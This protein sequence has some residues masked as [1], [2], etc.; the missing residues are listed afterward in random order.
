MRIPVSTSSPTMIPTAGGPP[1]ENEPPEVPSESRLRQLLEWQSEEPQEAS[2]ERT[3]QVVKEIGIAARE[4]AGIPVPLEDL[5]LE[6][7]PSY[8]F[9]KVFEV[10]HRKRE[11]AEGELD[12]DTLTTRNRFWSRRWRAWVSIVQDQEGNIFA[13][14]H[15]GSSTQCD[16][17]MNTLGAAD[18]WSLDQEF[19]ALKLARSVLSDRQFKQYL[20]TGM[21][22]ETSPRSQLVYLFRKLRPTLAL[23]TCKTLG[24]KEGEVRILTALCMHPVAY[25]SDSWAGAL[26]PTD[27]VIA[28]LMLMRG[29]E[30]MF[31]RRCNQHP[32]VRPEAGV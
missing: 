15:R 11:I 2:Y 18:A 9:A 31:W 1:L 17:L 22:L 25:Y 8:P 3:R 23:R 6:V 10:T 20:L 4:W 12:P 5:S 21:F 29:D 32:V 13:A 19:K 7:E 16:K 14:M 28:H 30:P 24:S 26:C 27:D